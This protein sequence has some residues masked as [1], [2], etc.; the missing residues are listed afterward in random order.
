M[1]PFTNPVY[2]SLVARY[3]GEIAPLPLLAPLL[4]LGVVTALVLRM[5]FA[6]PLAA[7]VLAAAWIWTGAGFY[8]GPFA[9]LYFAAPALGVIWILQGLLVAGIGLR[10]RAPSKHPSAAVRATGLGIAVAGLAAVP[11][12]DGLLSAPWTSVRLFGATPAPTL[13]A[14]FGIFL[15]L[16]G[17][18]TG[19]LII[20]PALL[21][22]ETAYTAWVLSRIQ[23]A[24][25][26][27]AAL[28]S[29]VTIAPP[30][31]TDNEKRRKNQ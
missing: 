21:T 15:L 13:L 30:G 23:D 20:L 26:P 2:F 18:G 11:V 5:P 9:D 6:E 12:L 4:G 25:L 28:L 31:M 7:L 10:R 1:L 24:L 22:L 16:R 8:L 27:L 17:K 29:L 14:S 3:Y 19:L